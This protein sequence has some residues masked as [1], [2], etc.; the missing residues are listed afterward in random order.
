[1]TLDEIN[2]LIGK[3]KN[4]ISVIETDL[5]RGG[6]KDHAEYKHSCG[7]IHGLKKAWSILADLQ[8]RLEMDDDDDD[9]TS[10]PL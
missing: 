5:G 7:V 2:Y 9:A 1:M 3:I 6:A 10:V 4:E 8:T